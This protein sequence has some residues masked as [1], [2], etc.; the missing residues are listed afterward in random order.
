M[1]GTE[2]LLIDTNII[3]YYLA[4]DPVVTAFLKQ[5]RDDVH[6]S[7]ITKMEVLSYPYQHDQEIVV[8]RFLECFQQH[9]L[10]DTIVE[11][12]IAL[13]KQKKIK[14]PDAIIAATALERRLTL[15]TRNTTD[16]RIMEL[17]LCNPFE[18]T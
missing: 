13:R 4:G 7:I 10:D 14:L 16:F 18:E 6:L 3:I 17:A 5:H 8:R 1:N 15:V 9:H 11:R 2:P 12:V